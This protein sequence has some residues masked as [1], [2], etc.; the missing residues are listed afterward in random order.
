VSILAL[1][2]VEGAEAVGDGVQR[3]RDLGDRQLG[4]ML[5]EQESENRLLGLSVFCCG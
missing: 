5:V 1:H 4:G 2:G 3:P